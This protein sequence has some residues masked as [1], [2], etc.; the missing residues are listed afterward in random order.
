M[1]LTGLPL[2][3]SVLPPR[4][5]LPYPPYHHRYIGWI[6]S[7][8]DSGECMVTDIPWAVAWYG[9]KTSILLP[10]DIDGFFEVDAKFQKVA[11]AYFTMVTRDKPWIRGLSDP[12]APDYS[13][14]QVFAAGKV[15]PNFPLTQGRFVAGTEQFILADRPRW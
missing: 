3:L 12:S 14:Y 10:K 2:L 6:A 13:W 15:P 11:M 7:M 1:F 5:G 8:V 9:G 4:T